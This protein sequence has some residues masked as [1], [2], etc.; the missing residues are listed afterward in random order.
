[1]AGAVCTSAVV[2][3]PTPAGFDTVPPRLTRVAKM[4]VDALR[5]SRQATRNVVSLP[6]TTGVI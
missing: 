5:P 1:M 3:M 2:L 4:S 6:A